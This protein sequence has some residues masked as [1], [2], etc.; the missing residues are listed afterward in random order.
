M[1]TRA[2]IL[3][4]VTPH[5]DQSALVEINEM[6]HEFDGKFS[7]PKLP[8]RGETAAVATFAY[9]T[10]ALFDDRVWSG[11]NED[12]P[13]DIA[14][15]GSTEVEEQSLLVATLVKYLNAQEQSESLLFAR[16]ALF[17][18]LAELSRQERD[19]QFGE[20]VNRTLSEQISAVHGIPVVPMYTS[21]AA[22]NREYVKGD[23]SVVVATLSEVAV[24]V[25]QR[26]TWEQVLE[27][28][29]DKEMSSRLRRLKHWLD[30]EF[31]GKSLA[32]VQDEI[33]N[34][35]EEYDAALK[36]H[37]IETILGSL[38]AV[39]DSQ[40]VIAGSAIAATV[41]YGS[42]WAWGLTTG[43]AVLATKAAIHLARAL[44]NL[45][46]IRRTTHP[47]ISFLAEVRKRVS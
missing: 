3:R 38:S 40:T 20:A 25:E 18:V 39:V 34:R 7:A 14:F 10:A 13:T 46:D 6:L 28:R 44:L 47:E 11:M 29:N 35:I 33:A 12:F 17:S 37:G 2:E 45:K 41:T 31:A 4:A 26:L 9:K 42:D 30:G 21:V 5:L 22:R 8:E 19:D 36:K 24:P 1:A 16:H 23:Y 43:G 32:Y 27:I 15:R